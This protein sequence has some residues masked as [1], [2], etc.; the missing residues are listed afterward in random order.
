M[1][2][3]NENLKVRFNESPKSKPRPS[4]NA[5]IDILRSHSCLEDTCTKR[6]KVLDC[7]NRKIDVMNCLNV[8]QA[9]PSQ[10]ATMS[11]SSMFRSGLITVV[12]DIFLCRG[13]LTARKEVIDEL[14]RKRW[15]TDQPTS[16]KQ[17]SFSV[18][19][20]NM[21]ALIVATIWM[22]SFRWFTRQCPPKWYFSNW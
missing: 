6:I 2:G 20:V 7:I 16:V 17:S 19:V 5:N 10:G 22:D 3:Q 9:H 1:D 14:L 12:F 18:C 8:I 4:N 15:V 21:V 11:M 13:V